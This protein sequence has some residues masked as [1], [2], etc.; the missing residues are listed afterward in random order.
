MVSIC[1]AIAPTEEDADVPALRKRWEALSD[2]PLRMTDPVEDITPVS[3]ASPGSFREATADAYRVVASKGRPQ[4]AGVSQAFAFVR[5]DV[6]GLA[7][8]QAPAETPD[9]LATWQA[10]FERW[11]TA[12]GADQ[13][14]DGLLAEVFVFTALC[15]RDPA[16]IAKL[17]ESIRESLPLAD[18]APVATPYAATEGVMLWGTSLREQPRVL[19]VIAPRES[20]HVLDSWI[21]WSRNTLP[22]LISYLLSGAKVRYE[23]DVH[24]DF[25]QLLA[26]GRRKIDDEIDS[27]FDEHLVDDRSTDPR[28]LDRLVDS[29][30]RIARAQTQTTGLIV[31]MTKLRELEHTV[32]IA[33]HNM[34]VHR[35][36]PQPDRTTDGP[37]V[38]DLDDQAAEWLAGQ[39]AHDVG[40]AE[41]VQE[42]ARETHEL[43]ALRLMRATEDRARRG[44]SILKLQMMLLAA[45]GTAIAAVS[46]TRDWPLWASLALAGALIIGS[47]GLMPLGFRLYERTRIAG[48]RKPERN[49]RGSPS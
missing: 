21:W 39:A 47:L 30:L 43:T 38:F 15:D 31:A 42:R 49:Q 3:V 13:S 22:G 11:E 46:L 23:L 2:D 17:S 6:A 4:N 45:V 36:D 12:T 20:E 29:Q 25:S 19:A 34:A 9:G 7:V 40:Y 37:S 18:Q 26:A 1:L 44:E 32:R 33:Q 41:A 14:A 8:L 5:H 28:A 10:L 35:L 16:S 48:E 24:R 27:L